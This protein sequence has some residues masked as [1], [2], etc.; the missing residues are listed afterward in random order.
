MISNRR[1]I[2]LSDLNEHSIERLPVLV[3]NVV[4]TA[5]D[6]KNGIIFWSDMKLKK[7]FRAFKNGSDVREVVGSGLDLVEGLSFDWIGRNVYW[8]DSRLHTIEACDEN[9]K[10]RAVIL[11]KNVSQPRGIVV[12]GREG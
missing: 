8:V 5:S 10:H 1:S 9:G 4:A 7:I 3:E 12:D 11:G 6:M 2:L